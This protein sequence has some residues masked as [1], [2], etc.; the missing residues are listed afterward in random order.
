[1]VEHRPCNPVVMGSIPI[2]GSMIMM[3]PPQR[4]AYLF[5][6]EH[7]LG[8][9]ARSLIGEGPLAIYLTGDTHYTYDLEKL[10]PKSFDTKGLT[11][12]DYVIILGDWGFVWT[13][14]CGPESKLYGDY[15]E[16]ERWVDW[17]ESQP[18]TTLWIDGNH[19]NFDLLKSYP[20]YEWGGGKVLQALVLRPLP[21]RS[22]VG[23]TLHLPVQRGVRPRRHGEDQV[24]DEHRHLRRILRP[25][26]SQTPMEAL[27]GDMS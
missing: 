5:V 26:S 24:R 20:E 22:V 3:P 19:E 7:G 11:R 21:R 13:P 1:M 4:E 23:E 27:A 10:L 12:D 14:Q 17:F 2:S 8:R 9:G 15:L 6:A 18:Y 25:V 16:Q